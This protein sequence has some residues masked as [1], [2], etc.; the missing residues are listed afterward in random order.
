MVGY[1]NETSAYDSGSINDNAYIGSS[2]G[3]GTYFVEVNVS[4]YGSTNTN[5]TVNLSA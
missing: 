5:Y 1:Y 3:A 4:S 2:L